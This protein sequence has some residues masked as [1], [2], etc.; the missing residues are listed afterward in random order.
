MLVCVYRCCGQFALGCCGLCCVWLLMFKVDIC[1]FMRAM[2]CVVG[3]A[4]VVV[5]GFF[6]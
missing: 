5:L 4:F 2:C 3:C 1:G 6:I